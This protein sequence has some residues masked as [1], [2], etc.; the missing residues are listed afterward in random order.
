MK[1]ISFSTMSSDVGAHRLFSC[2]DAQSP[3]RVVARQ[4]A[5]HG[6]GFFRVHCEVRAAFAVHEQLRER[7]LL[8]RIGVRGELLADFSRTSGGPSV[9]AIDARTA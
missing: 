6:G 9:V 1:T 5:R 8:G 2:L 3:D 7:P 4:R